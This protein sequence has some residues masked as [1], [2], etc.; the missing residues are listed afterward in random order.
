MEKELKHLRVDGKT[1]ER[2]PY[3]ER[4]DLPGPCSA[5]GADVGEF[6]AVGCPHEMCP[7]CGDK[8]LNECNWHDGFTD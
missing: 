1:V 6:H 7:V 8:T 5:C 4:P 3:Q 2:V